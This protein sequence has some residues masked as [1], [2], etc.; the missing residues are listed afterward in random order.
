MSMRYENLPSP[1]RAVLV[2]QVGDRRHSST[3]E[4]YSWAAPCQSLPHIRYLGPTPAAAITRN[5]ALH[6]AQCD[7]RL[8]ADTRFP[9]RH[10]KFFFRLK[11]NNRKAWIPLIGV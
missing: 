9:C 4:S 2:V 10:A 11:A 3:P 6:F 8:T 7:R 1:L 5:Q